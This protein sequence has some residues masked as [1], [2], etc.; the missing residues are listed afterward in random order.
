MSI[1]SL[2]LWLALAGGVLPH[3]GAARA[4][5]DAPVV[6]SGPADVPQ[7]AR[8][9]RVA[10]KQVAGK[11]VVACDLAT[12]VRRIPVNL[13][14]DFER[15]IA[16]ELH[17]GAAGRQALDVE[18]TQPP[19]EVRILFPEFEL[20]TN[21]R[22][23]GD[24]DF[25]NDFTKFHSHEIG[26]NAVVGAIGAQLLAQHFVVLDL[27]AGQLQIREPRAQGEAQPRLAAATERDFDVPISLD[28]GFV[29]LPARLPNGESGVMA[30]G[31][32]RHDTLFDEELAAELGA[33]AGD[34][35]SLR[36]GPLDVAAMVALRP[37][38][39][40]LVHPDRAL[41]QL[42]LG[43]LASV[44]VE[45]DRVNRF[46]RIERVRELPFPEADR[47]YFRARLADD[48]DTTEAHLDAHPTARL[49][50]EA[51]RLLV[52]QRLSAFASGDE[53]GRALDWFVRTAPEDL[54]CTSALEL[55][56]ELQAEGQ[57]EAAVLLGE[58]GLEHGRKDRYP[59]A[60][61]KVRTRLGQ[62]LY[63]A[64]DLDRA[65]RHLLAAAFGTPDDGLVNLYLGRIY[66]DQGKLVRAQSRYVQAV[67]RTE[68]G[69]QALEGLA[70]VS[71][72]LGDVGG[73]SFDTVER[74]VAGKVYGF[75]AATKYEPPTGV[76]P[77]RRVLVEYFAGANLDYRAAVG[78][79]LAFEGLASHFDDDFAIP[80]TYHHAVP[81]LSPLCNPAADAAA[82]ER[83]AAG[84]I[85]FV[86][87]GTTGARA[88]G[89]Q[90][91]A[92]ALFNDARRAVVQELGQFVDHEV[93]VTARFENGRLVGRVVAS[94]PADPDFDLCVL[95]VERGV[96]YP[97]ASTVVL[98]RHVVR[99][100]L[101][102]RPSGVPWSGDEDTLEYAFDVALSDLEAENRRHLDAAVAAG[103]AAVPTVGVR[104]D[105]R[106]LSV[107]A[108]L[109]D[110]SNGE[111]V[112]ANRA[113]VE[114]REEEL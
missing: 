111:V 37:E 54:R 77:N 69:P 70:R 61:P 47:A 58:R 42:G 88:A 46:V 25:Y 53:L 16:L 6:E 48:G 102:D 28:S 57:A 82:V 78:G 13:F 17:N 85:L 87:G 79:A 68:S 65:W 113:P 23:H 5:D 59:D 101:T 63:E 71:E 74:L 21:G 34:L 52:D 24:E 92:E 95:L 83:G 110:R 27:P 96:L 91:D 76:L 60:A 84:N 62:M 12:D 29:W 26:E 35:T 36:I 45:I 109:V 9:G 86:V 32:G 98:H 30:L 11:L 38:P 89:R 20:R 93:E 51:A 33:P 64:G 2:A 19:R 14:V 81:T 73:L 4:Q 15:P 56:K 1:R 100:S 49:A 44:R 112:Q 31:T 67:I 8:S 108:F 10:V 18:G 7:R 50:P 72:K 80:I 104:M 114:N 41:G 66:E 107:V 40:T 90:R 103:A 3:H 39:S 94:G 105:P 99:S 43:F 97:G 75:G 106:Q 22:T 55:V